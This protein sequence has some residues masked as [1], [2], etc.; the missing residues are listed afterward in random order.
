MTRFPELDSLVSAPLPFCKVILALGNDG[1]LRGD[2]SGIVS[3]GVVMAVTVTA[4]TSK[5]EVLPAREWDVVEAACEMMF[6]L[7]DSKRKVSSFWSSLNE[8]C[9]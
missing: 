5:G 1:D 8:H 3:S 2:L 6:L 7:D 4:A 9:F